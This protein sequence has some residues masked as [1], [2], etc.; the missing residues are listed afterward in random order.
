MSAAKSPNANT[1]GASSLRDI[2]GD[3][4]HRIGTLLTDVKCVPAAICQQRDGRRSRRA[5]IVTMRLM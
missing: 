1:P 4:I 2:I 3:I 5:L